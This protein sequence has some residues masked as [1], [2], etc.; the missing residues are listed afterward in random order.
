MGKAASF[1]EQQDGAGQ[2]PVVLVIDGRAMRQF[3]TSIFL[4]RMH[5]HVIMAKTAED[6]LLFLE[7]TVPLAIIANYD[8]PAMSGFELLQHVKETESIR[9]VPFV[10][11]TSNKDPAVQKACEEAGCAGFLRYPCSLDDLYRIVQ[12]ATG[13]RPREFVRLSTRLEVEILDAGEDRHDFISDISESGMFV[14][15]N[16]PLSYGT[17]HTF[18]FSLPNAPGWILRVEGQIQHMHPLQDHRKRP[19][20]GVKFL[21]IGDSERELIKEFVKQELMDGIARD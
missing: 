9:D 12:Q 20:M 17:I 7:L 5:Y 1:G 8:L 4:Q 3:Y 11:Y 19:G 2:K 6:A 14:S 21:R 16:A 13:L 15:T 18:S 10:I